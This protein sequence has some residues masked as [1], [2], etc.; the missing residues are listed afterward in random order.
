MGTFI[1]V[2]IAYFF[3]DAL[4]VVYMKY[5]KEHLPWRSGFVAAL[6]YVLTAYGVVSFTKDPIYIL[7]IAGGSLFGTA[8]VVRWQTPKGYHEQDVS[9][10]LVR[11]ANGT[12][13]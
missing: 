1:L 2:F 10:P 9:T 12:D 7:A 11:E 6:M 3:I 4:F 13:D 8:L 5:V